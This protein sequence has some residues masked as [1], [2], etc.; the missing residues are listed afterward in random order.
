MVLDDLNTSPNFRLTKILGLLESLYGMTIDFEAA[1]STAELQSIYEAYGLERTR[2]IKEAAF[3]SHYNDP[4]Y[5][6]AVLIQEA[7]HIF[8]SEVAPKRIKRSKNSA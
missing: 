2:I 6:K 7:I 1:N 4:G 5:T 8:L 3:N